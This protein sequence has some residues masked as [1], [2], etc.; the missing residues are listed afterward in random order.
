[1]KFSRKLSAL[2]LAAL[3]AA[4]GPAMA[5]TVRVTLQA[6]L[7]T[8]AFAAPAPIALSAP[9]FAAPSLASPLAAA[10]PV[11]PAPAIQIAPVAV[12]PS[13]LAVTVMSAPSTAERPGESQKADADA[14]FDASAAPAAASAVAVPDLDR[15]IATL[16]R[17]SAPRP[18]LEKG[19]VVLAYGGLTA[20][21]VALN[22][23]FEHIGPMVVGAIMSPMLSFMGLFFYGASQSAVDGPAPDGEAVQPSPET[24]GMIARLAAEAKVPMP[25][26]VKVMPGDKVQAQVGARDDKGYEIRFTKAFEDL[27]PEVKEG[28]LRH[29]FAHERHHDMPWTI[30][31]A[32]LAPLPVMMG[33]MSLDGKSTL[34]GLL[35]A[36]IATVAIVLFPA[37][38]RR[39]EYLAD[40]YAASKSEGAGPLA[41]F[42][43]EDDENPARA[44]TALAG[45]PFASES[46]WKRRA[47]LA[48]D[49]LKTSYKA[50]PSHDRRIARLA[51]LSAKGKAKGR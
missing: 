42:F 48:W 47:L 51:R 15:R 26:R 7:G 9:S 28:I 20:A 25:A 43:I 10:I 49:W 3:V 11:L 36:A 22:A 23:P 29:E 2:A 41:R 44:A 8:P 37:T 27:R 39:S 4:P 14:L 33:L 34:E 5:Q 35:V 50:H 17:V 24:M 31:N 19:K 32:F 6:P 12:V 38:L 40:Q 16:G 30:V 45:K 13:A 21:A 1:M 18:W 46:G